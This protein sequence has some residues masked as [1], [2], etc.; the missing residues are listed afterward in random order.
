IKNFILLSILLFFELDGHFYMETYDP[1]FLICF[2][3]LFDIKIAH[4]FF[5]ESVLRKINFLFL[6]LLLFY[7]AKL[8]HVYL[9]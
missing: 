4:N 6:Y 3:L 1:L 5:N 9:I 8:T 2:F 7:L